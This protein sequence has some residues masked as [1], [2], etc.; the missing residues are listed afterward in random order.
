MSIAAGRIWRGAASVVLDLVVHDSLYISRGER[1]DKPRGEELFAVP[2]DITA[3][4]Y[5]TYPIVKGSI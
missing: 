1:K 4:H 5:G 3:F 2:L